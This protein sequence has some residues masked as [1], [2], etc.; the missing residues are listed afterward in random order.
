[1]KP[2]RFHINLIDL[3]QSIKEK[4]KNKLD[5]LVNILNKDIDEYREI[6]N[7][8][9]SCDKIYFTQLMNHFRKPLQKL[10]YT[11]HKVNV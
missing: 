3:S 2:F 1:M 9:F 8:L 5:E 6:R 10:G 11:I 4:D 7:N